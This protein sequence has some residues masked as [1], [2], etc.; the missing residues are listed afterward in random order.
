MRAVALSVALLVA[1]GGTPS[2]FAPSR[3]RSPI[4]AEIAVDGAHEAASL[5]RDEWARRLGVSLPAPP[6][7]RWFAGDPLR[8]KGSTL[9]VHSLYR[10]GLEIQIGGADGKRPSAT[11]LAHELL[12]WA[13]DTAGR[14]PDG[15]HAGPLWRDVGAVSAVL[16]A[17]GL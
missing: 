13:L 3:A 15:A 7:V 14:D 17:A 9:A 10:R 16:R 8:Y 12:H 5:A 6:R 11:D 1:C 4:N 2:T